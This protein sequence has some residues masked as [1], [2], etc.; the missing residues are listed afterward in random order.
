MLIIYEGQRNKHFGYKLHPNH[1]WFTCYQS[2]SRILHPMQKM[3]F[4]VK[5]FSMR[6]RNNKKSSTNTF[7]CRPA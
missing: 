4:V 5:N 6:K 3:C 2:N 1:F 7:F